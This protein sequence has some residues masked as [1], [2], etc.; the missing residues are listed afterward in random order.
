M[1]AVII[2][3]EKMKNKALKKRVLLEKSAFFLFSKKFFQKNVIFFKKW[4][5]FK[6]PVFQGIDG[7]FGFPVNFQYYTKY[8]IIFIFLH[9]MV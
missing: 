5:T 1:Y 2:D 3:L 6:K 8:V 9:K 7:F 4:K